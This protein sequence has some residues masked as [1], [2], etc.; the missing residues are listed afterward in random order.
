VVAAA[1]LGFGFML[2]ILPYYHASR[3]Y[4]FTRSWSEIFTMLPRIQSYLLADNSQL[5]SS[6]ANFLPN[7]PLRWEHQLFPGLAV[8]TLVLAGI[9]WRF[10]TDNRMLAWLHF[11]AALSLIIFTLNVHGF[12]LYLLVWML[13]G[14]SSIRAITRIMLVVMWPLSLFIAWVVDGYILRFT[15]QRRWMQTAA[16]LIVG[17]LVVESVFYTHATYVKADAQSR[18]DKLAQQIP[19]IVNANPILYVEENLEDPSYATEIDAML[20]SQ[21]LGW[22]TLN[23]YSGNYPPGYKSSTSCAQLP[24]LIKNYMD[25]T[26]ISSESFYLEI[27]KRV[28]PIGFKDC[29]P[30]WWEQ[31]P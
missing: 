2:L 24:E 6:I 26:G 5:W 12:S 20:L 4:G 19:A 14:M 23:G 21:E 30:S 29:D 31:M 16:F 8:I 22:S 11:S 9:A 10:H 3:V 28:V 17:L 1:V 27:M 18:L 15:Q 7:F 13:P 25:F